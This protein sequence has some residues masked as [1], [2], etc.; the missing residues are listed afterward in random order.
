[1]L[2]REHLLLINRTNEPIPDQLIILTRQMFHRAKTVENRK[3]IILY[4]LA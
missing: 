3:I 4:L 1:M 2:H